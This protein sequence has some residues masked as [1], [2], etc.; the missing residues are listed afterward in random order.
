MKI[1]NM[2]RTLL[3]SSLVLG[4]S[5]SITGCQ[6]LWDFLREHGHHHHDAGPMDAGPSDGGGDE[7]A[8]IDQDASAPDED[9]G[10]ALVV[11]GGLLGL[12]CDEGEYCKFAIEA[13]C[14]AADQTGFCADI[15]EVCTLEYDP[16]CGCNGSTYSNACTAA[17][18][19]VS[20]ASLG[21]CSPL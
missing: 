10:G 20:V 19:G 1:T 6:K 18:A 11:C 9:A 21:E 4:L 13:M 16:V 15:P 5:T 12:G 7:D 14:G 2:L 3:L 8:G 17:A